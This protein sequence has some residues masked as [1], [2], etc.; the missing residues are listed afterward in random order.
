MLMHSLSL[1][2][3]VEPKYGWPR[4]DLA[5]ALATFV[6]GNYAAMTGEK[7]AEHVAAVATQL[8]S[9]APLRAALSRQDPQALRNFFEQQAMVGTFMILAQ[10]THEGQP[11]APEQLAQLRQQARENLRLV[12][13]RDPAQMSIGPQGV[14]LPPPAAAPPGAT[15][16]PQGVSGTLWHNNYLIAGQSGVQL[17]TLNGGPSTS[18]T[19]NREHDVYV[20]PDGGQYMVASVNVRYGHTDITVIDRASGKTAHQGRLTGR[21]HGASP[22]PADKR[23]VQ[24][25]QTYETLGPADEYILDLTTLKRLRTIADDDQFAW[26]PDGR[27]MLISRITGSMRIGSL[28]STA[29]MVVGRLQLPEDRAMGDFSVSPNGRQLMMVLPRRA[30]VPRESNLWIANI[31]GSSLEQLTDVK[32]FGGARWS[33]DGRYV[34]YKVDT[35][36][37]CSTAGFCA[38]S[39]DQ[40]YTPVELRKV[41]GQDGQPGSRNFMI[42]GR[43]GKPEPLGCS[44]IAWTP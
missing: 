35:G 6:V 24:V 25:S 41:K 39:C 17:A 43:F 14:R 44:V 22:S 16:A 26:L 38:G 40:Y 11:L 37:A 31:D 10:K 32:A 2:E 30:A 12:L 28:G 8:R 7:A 18:V 1:Y 27:F 3:K 42:T 4:N 5:G 23:L 34:T 20:W 15:A 21:M 29:E 36:H 13:M 9:S 33:P 19:H